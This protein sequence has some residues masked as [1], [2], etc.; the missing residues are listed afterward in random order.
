MILKYFFWKSTFRSRFYVLRLKKG[1][2]FTMNIIVAHTRINTKHSF[3][4]RHSLTIV[5]IPR[6][7]H[8]IGS[9]VQLKG[10]R[11]KIGY[12]HI[13]HGLCTGTGTASVS[14]KQPLRA[15]VDEWQRIWYLDHIT[16]YDRRSKYRGPIERVI[17][18][19][20]ASTT[21]LGKLTKV[22]HTYLRWAMGRH[23]CFIMN[24]SRHISMAPNII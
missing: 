20:M 21:M 23:L 14:V 22:N 11:L 19:N 24:N 2:L 4:N 17:A 10:V 9:L 12:T 15:W 18:Y 3:S 6:T 16:P 13:V 5:C 7:M 8:M 1:F